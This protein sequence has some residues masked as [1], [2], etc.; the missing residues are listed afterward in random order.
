LTAVDFTPPIRKA[1]VFDKNYHF[2][3]EINF[4]FG[5]S[6]KYLNPGKM[7][8]L[9]VG[10]VKTQSCRVSKNS[11]LVTPCCLTSKLI[12]RGQVLFFPFSRFSVFR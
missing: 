5:L 4:F 2:F 10:D 3:S 11:A 9:V 7:I 12:S 1:E 8:W 6:Q